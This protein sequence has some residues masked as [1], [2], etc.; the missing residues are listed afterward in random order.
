MYICM[1]IYIY[2]CV[3]T[4]LHIHVHI[5]THVC[6]CVSVNVCVNVCVCVCVRAYMCVYIWES[7]EKVVQVSFLFHPCWV[8]H[9]K[10]RL[11]DLVASVFTCCAKGPWVYS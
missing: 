8:L 5:Y 6:V 2:M 9:L 7:G 3:C 10:F 4:H 11:S 1:Y